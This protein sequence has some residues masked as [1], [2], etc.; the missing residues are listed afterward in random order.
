[1]TGFTDH[2]ARMMLETL[3]S[4]YPY[5]ALYTTIG[6]DDEVGFVEVS[7]G[8]YARCATGSGDWGPIS[9]TEPTVMINQPALNFPT[10][11]ADWGTVYGWGLVDSPTSGSIGVFDYLGNYPWIPT[12]IAQGSPGIITAAK[13]H[14]YL[15]GDYLVFTIE[16]SGSMP[17]FSQ[18]SLTGILRAAHVTADM[19][20]VTVGGLQVNTSS[21]GSG[22][23]KKITP[24]AIISGQSPISFS[25]GSLRISVA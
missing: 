24:Q 11:T 13:D 8:S 14:G 22:K 17:T 25:A 4:T 23:I 12:S 6:T 3:I 19:V 15:V 7:G 21:T 1:M 18:G 2:S 5:V 20:D 10:P 16:G 9:G